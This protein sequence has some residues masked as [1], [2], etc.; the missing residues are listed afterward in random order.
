MRSSALRALVAI[1]LIAAP[2]AASGTP[3]PDEGI[4]AAGP[5]VAAQTGF[6]GVDALAFNELVLGSRG[7]PVRW[8]EA[9]ELVILMSVMQ[10]RAGESTVY[11]ATSERLTD[12]E[13]DHLV[14]DL[15]AALELMTGGRFTAFAGV[16]R[17]LVDTHG[18]T[19]VLRPGQ[20]V[21]GRFRGVR[22]NANTLGLGGRTVRANGTIASGAL[23][24]DSDFDR[25][26]DRRRLLRTH[27]LGHAL[28]YNHVA[29]RSSIM[30]AR[31]GTDVTDFDRRAAA[32]ISRRASTIDHQPELTA[33]VK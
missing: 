16:R 32:A 17:E 22:E 21:V 19:Q 18:T 3:D 20:I 14:D 33:S 24:L 28:G 30:N 5:G 2:G 29:A 27:E 6:G 8:D 13:A 31:I 4:K 10:Y 1:T 11:N 23:L 26:S 15:T 7:R 12:G 9:P 25:A